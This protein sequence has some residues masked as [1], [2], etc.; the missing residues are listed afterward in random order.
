MRDSSTTFNGLMKGGM[1]VDGTNFW[2]TRRTYCIG[3]TELGSM[4]FLR[5][6]TDI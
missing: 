5:L 2:Y 4:L 1:V 3:G 6:H